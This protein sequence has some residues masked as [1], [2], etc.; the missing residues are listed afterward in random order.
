MEHDAVLKNST[1]YPLNNEKAFGYIFNDSLGRFKDGEQII[2]S[3]IKEHIRDHHGVTTHLVTRS[4]T[5]YKLV[6][7]DLQDNG[8][9]M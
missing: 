5:V 4:G 6:Y 3:T 1:P 7:G 9:V 2:T 8:D